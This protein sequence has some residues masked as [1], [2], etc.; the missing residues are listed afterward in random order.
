M[1]RMLHTTLSAV[2]AIESSRFCAIRALIM[3]VHSITRTAADHADGLDHSCLL[4]PQTE[5]HRPA[6]N[7][8]L[9]LQHA[10]RR[11]Y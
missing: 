9:S 10:T 11:I 1:L 8:G 2:F 3:S 7:F 5:P 4:Q 6:C